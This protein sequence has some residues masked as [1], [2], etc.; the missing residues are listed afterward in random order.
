[1]YTE[2]KSKIF[3]NN[4][5]QGRF[6]YLFV[7]I[8]R[9]LRSEIMLE[10]MTQRFYTKLLT[11]EVRLL[12]LESHSL[13]FTSFGFKIESRHTQ[14]N[15]LGTIFDIFMGINNTINNFDRSYVFFLCLISCPIMQK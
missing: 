2:E 3:K 15:L 9:Q 7:V 8:K 11:K 4:S 5:T 1:M 14:L 13:M 6:I 10:F 12:K